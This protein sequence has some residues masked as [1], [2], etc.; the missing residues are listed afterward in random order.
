MREVTHTGKRKKLRPH[1]IGPFRIL[2]KVQP[3]TYRL[4]LPTEMSKSHNVFY[5][6]QLKLF[7]REVEENQKNTAPISDVGMK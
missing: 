1:Y 6:S 7:H 2:E 5:V 4:E 3:S